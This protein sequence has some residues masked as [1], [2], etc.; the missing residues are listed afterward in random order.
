M[1]YKLLLGGAL[2]AVTMSV[3]TS[4]S[5]AV[6][7]TQAAAALS[8]AIDSVDVVEQVARRASA[9]G[10]DRAGRGNVGGAD[11]AG[12]GNVGGPDR[13]NANRANVGRADGNR[14]NLNRA[15]VN[16]ADVNR[17]DVNRANINSANVN[18][19]V[20]VNRAN[21]AV[22]KPWSRKPYY[23]TIVAGVALGSVVA[24]TAYGLSPTS[25]SSNLCW[26]WADNSMAQGYWDYC[27]AQ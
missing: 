2:L 16:R 19:R 13:G 24:A 15:D 25:P 11:R 23:G 4:P 8:E 9:A 6:P 22:V 1:A 20:D 7:A 10:G 27:Q 17:A 3:P 5:F 14:T 12:R 26:N 21:A 18:R